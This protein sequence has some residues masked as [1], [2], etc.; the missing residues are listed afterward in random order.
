MTTDIT[1]DTTAVTENASLNYSTALNGYTVTLTGTGNDTV[2]GSQYD[3]K[4]LGGDGADL[5]KG[6]QVDKILYMAVM[7]TI[8]WMVV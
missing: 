8:L 3:D 2:T 1:I 6:G 4:I 5:L 7:G